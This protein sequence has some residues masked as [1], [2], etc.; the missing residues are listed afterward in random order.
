MS[1]CILVKQKTEKCETIYGKKCDFDLDKDWCENCALI[2][3]SESQEIMD[4]L[5][6]CG[7]NID[8]ICEE[9]FV[10]D[11][12]DHHRIWWVMISGRKEKEPDLE[13]VT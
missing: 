3:E 12:Y 7:Y 8:D 6:S 10:Y 9:S 5:V 11:N 4:E 2:Y 13:I 1:R